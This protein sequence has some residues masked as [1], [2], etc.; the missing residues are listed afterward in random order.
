LPDELFAGVVDINC[1]VPQPV[2]A[3]RRRDEPRAGDLHRGPH[4]GEAPRLV[5]HLAAAQRGEYGGIEYGGLLVAVNTVAA[6]LLSSRSEIHEARSGGRAQGSRA[7]SIVVDLH[8]DRAGE[9]Y[10][11]VSLKQGL[12]K[13]E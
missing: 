2:Y 5:C 9:G 4:P 10:T 8:D 11:S 13:G 1:P 7:V 6:K 3:Q 12:R